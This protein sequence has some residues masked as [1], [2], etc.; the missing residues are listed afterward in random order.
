MAPVS[1]VLTSSKLLNRMYPCLAATIF[2]LS[3]KERNFSNL[4]HKYIIWVFKKQILACFP[5]KSL[6][7]MKSKP[8]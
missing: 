6:P 5:H 4:S 7:I 1:C 3:Y 8:L 2:R